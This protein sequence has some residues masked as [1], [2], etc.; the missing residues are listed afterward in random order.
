MPANSKQMEHQR[1]LLNQLDNDMMRADGLD[2][3]KQQKQRPAY[4]E[5]ARAKLQEEEHER[6]R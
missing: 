3:V 5:K 4:V 1:K 6:S 2:P